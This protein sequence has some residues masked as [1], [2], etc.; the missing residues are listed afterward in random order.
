MTRFHVA[1]RVSLLLLVASAGACAGSGS[2]GEYV[3]TPFAAAPTSP[4]TATAAAEPVSSTA[5]IS[6]ERLPVAEFVRATE[7]S[8]VVP[9]LPVEVL[10]RGEFSIGLSGRRALGE[11]GML[12]DWGEPGQEGPFWMKNTHIDLDIAFI[13]KDLRIV[14]IRSMRAESEEYVYSA[15]PYQSAIEAPAG[16]YAAHGVREGDRVRYVAPPPPTP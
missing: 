14:S 4:V 15:K 5:S 1:H 3:P 7:A 2:S 11:R 6:V 9:R 16:W 10:P 13:D 12:F 8:G